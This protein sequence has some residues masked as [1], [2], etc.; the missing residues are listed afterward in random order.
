[1]GRGSGLARRGGCLIRLEPC[2]FRSEPDTGERVGEES[3]FHLQGIRVLLLEILL[4]IKVAESFVDQVEIFV[5]S[6]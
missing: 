4:P 1:M 2:F 6:N 3:G 5:L